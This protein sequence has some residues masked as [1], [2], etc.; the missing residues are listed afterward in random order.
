MISEGVGQMTRCWRRLWR[1][2]G[3]VRGRGV[4]GER[5]ERGQHSGS[6]SCR[7]RGNTTKGPS[8]R[9]ILEKKKKNKLRRDVFPTRH[10]HHHHQ[11]YMTMR[12][13]KTDILVRPL[14]ASCYNHHTTPPPIKKNKVIERRDRR[15]N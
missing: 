2:C 11:A 7:N 15:L 1:G 3:C 12:R 5:L 13:Q 4:R 6:C 10:H 8:E 14:N 9:F